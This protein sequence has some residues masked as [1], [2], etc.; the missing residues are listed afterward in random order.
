MFCC[1]FCKAVMYQRAQLE[2]KKHPE[3]AA[4][5]ADYDWQCVL[6]FFSLF[7]SKNHIFINA[8]SEKDTKIQKKTKTQKKNS[9]C[10]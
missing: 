7:F 6:C 4:R 5:A 8:K 3:A 2:L 1:L 9:E 10:Y